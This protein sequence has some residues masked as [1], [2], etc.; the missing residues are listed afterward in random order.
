MHRDVMALVKGGYS[1]QEIIDA[2]VGVYGERAL[3][4]PRTSGFNLLAWLTPGVLVIAG[5]V[6]LSMWLRGRQRPVSRT[7]PQAARKPLDI[8]GLDATP[9]ELAR[10][11]AAVKGDEGA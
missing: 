11:E 3:M 5:G 8:P 9:E 1:A 2:F 6:A 4:A 10:L 7:V